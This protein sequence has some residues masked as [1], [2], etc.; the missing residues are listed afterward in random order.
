MYRKAFK[1]V[2]RFCPKC[3]RRELAHTVRVEA[4]S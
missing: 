4:K 2:P 3:G 1:D